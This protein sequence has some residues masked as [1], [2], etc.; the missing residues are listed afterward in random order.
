MKTALP[1]L[2]LGLAARA[3]TA[4]PW[5]ATPPPGWVEDAALAS[6]QMAQLKSLPQTKSIE[7]TI[8]V[9][10]ERD[11]QLT[12]MVWSLELTP[13]SKDAINQFDQGM[14]QG[15]AEKATAHLSDSR[16]FDNNQIIGDSVDQLNA[17]TIHYKRIY[18]LDKDGIVH[19]V[20]AICTKQG[21]ALG[22]CDTALA[23]LHLD[24]PNAADIE[25]AEAK[26]SVKQIGIAVGVVIAVLLVIWG[27][28]RF[29]A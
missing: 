25:S 21:A 10:P 22:P 28:R 26:D 6:G 5:P 23:S 16:T 18:G 20:S 7:A 3:A 8:Y 9:S 12:M 4:S 1:I 17:L 11:A 13:I 15:A 19:M 24:L 27:T 29:R 14:A 2:L